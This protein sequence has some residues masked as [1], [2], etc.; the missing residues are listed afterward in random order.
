MAKNS[1]QRS[2][3]CQEPENSAA[4]SPHGDFKQIPSGF[5]LLLPIFHTVENFYPFSTQS[6]NWFQNVFKTLQTSPLLPVQ[7]CESCIVAT[8]RGECCMQPWINRG[9]K[10]G[11]IILYKF[12]MCPSLQVPPELSIARHIKV[13]ASCFLSQRWKQVLHF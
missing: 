8:G 12:C 2:K 10:K 11:K 13:Y 4:K 6:K 5:W 9:H 7:K 3:G 1:F